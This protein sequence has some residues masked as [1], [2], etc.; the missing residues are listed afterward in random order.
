M[1][2]QFDT[3]EQALIERLRR[4]PQPELAADVRTAIRVRV[5][6][7]L[8]HPPIPAPRPALPRPILVIAVVLVA[9]ALI[10]GGVLLVLSQQKQTIVTPTAT[11][12]PTMSAMPTITVPAIISSPVA[13]GTYIP[14]P[15]PTADVTLSPTP[16]PTASVS[17]IIVIEG[18]VEQINGNVITIYGTQV[19][20]PANDPI[21]TSISIG[22][23]VHVEVNNQTVTTHIVI[24]QPTVVGNTDTNTN[25][26]SGEVWKDDGNCSHPPPDWAPANGW[27]RR[28]QGKD[29]DKGDKHDKG[30]D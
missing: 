24:V 5:L 3:P 27:R 2:E 29:K 13:T 10:A 21:L 25:P 9:A 12:A 14:Q 15:T 6:D 8:D 11:I 20:I 30:D 19:E 23:I 1:S 28:C 4:A 18:P 17:T 22:V 7:A 16:A 26:S